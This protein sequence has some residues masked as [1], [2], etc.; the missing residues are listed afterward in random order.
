MTPA[1]RASHAGKKST[2][3]KHNNP[4]PNSL[5]GFDSLPFD[6]LQTGLQGWNEGQSSWNNEFVEDS[7][8]YLAVKAANRASAKVVSHSV[9]QAWAY[10]RQRQPRPS[11]QS[12]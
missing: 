10:I 12:R 2:A 11:R 8:A 9:G 7:P 6:A 4:L 5:V 1:P 3:R